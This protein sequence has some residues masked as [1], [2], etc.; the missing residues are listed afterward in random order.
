MEGFEG[1]PDVWERKDTS[2]FTGL[3]GGLD[4]G[5]RLQQGSAKISI[6][7]RS[8]ASRSSPDH[9]GALGGQSDALL[10]RDLDFTDVS[11]SFQACLKPRRDLL[12]TPGK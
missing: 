3:P 5:G 1:H 7:S 12:K 4:A 9:R 8:E 6:A 2:C 10:H 11:D